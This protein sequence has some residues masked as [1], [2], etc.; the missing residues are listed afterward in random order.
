MRYVRKKAEQRFGHLYTV[1]EGDE[2]HYC[3]LPSDGHDHQPAIFT[4]HKFAADRLVTRKQIEERFGACYTVP[5]CI[6][7]NMGIGSFEGE[8]DDDRR[9]EILGFLDFFDQEGPSK[10]HWNYGAFLVAYEILLLRYQNAVGEEVYAIPS[11][12]RAI[13]AHALRAKMGEWED[14]PFWMTHREGFAKWLTA[15][16]GRK[17]KHFLDMAGL[18]SYSF[19]PGVYGR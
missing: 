15:V 8:S 18:E 3:G 1:V 14:H 4:L 10:G 2:C 16:P 6:I 9:Q 17:Q 13:M 5:A 12:G 11:I 7:C 19:R